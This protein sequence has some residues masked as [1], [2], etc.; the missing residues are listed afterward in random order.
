MKTIDI[1]QIVP[2]EQ[3]ERVRPILRPLFIQEKGRRRLVVGEH[4]TLLF[5]NAQ[6]V[7]YQIEE[8]LRVERIKDGDAVKHE[9]ETYNELIPREDELSATMLI[10]YPDAKERDLALKGLVG[11][12]RHFRLVADGRAVNAIFAGTQ[13]AED[14][15]SSVQ[16]VRFPLPRGLGANFVALAQKGALAIEV[17]HPMLAAR[18][19]IDVTLA[20]ALHADLSAT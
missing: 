6:S 8:M 20:Q 15:I 13:I 2:F 16:F 17:D 4:V 14:T 1:A 10:E 11:L 3:W 5:E 7:W 19:Q 9:V 12:D 18:A